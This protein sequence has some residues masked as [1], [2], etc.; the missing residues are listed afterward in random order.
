MAG[1]KPEQFSASSDETRNPYIVAV[2][3]T[4]RA[5]EPELAKLALK[6][7]IKSAGSG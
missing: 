2:S 5:L 7:F 6:K 4:M 1:V 3:P